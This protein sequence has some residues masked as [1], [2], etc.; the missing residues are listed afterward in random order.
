MKKFRKYLVG[1]PR[2][3]PPVGVDDPDGDSATPDPAR[4]LISNGMIG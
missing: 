2:L 3:F 1:R 4:F